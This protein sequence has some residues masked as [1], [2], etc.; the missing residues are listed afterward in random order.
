[1]EEY[2]QRLE[3]EIDGIL[4]KK[5]ENAQEYEKNQ[6][7]RYK[8]LVWYAVSIYLYNQLYRYF[9]PLLSDKDMYSLYNGITN[10]LNYMRSENESPFSME[11]PHNGDETYKS[12]I[13]DTHVA[14]I[15]EKIP[16]CLLSLLKDF[17][18]IEVFYRVRV[19][20]DLIQ[21]VLEDSTKN[22]ESSKKEK[23]DPTKNKE[24]SK[25]KEDSREIL[26]IGFL[27]KDNYFQLLFCEE[28]E[29][30]KD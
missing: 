10:F 12:A 17:R 30:G 8:A 26:E 3:K 18:G 21:E 24:S 20:H 23:E 1:M 25:K 5:K 13:K 14:K 29:E 19:K 4:E 6:I 28:K 16:E 7:K 15:I 27:K 22:K 9:L 2:R 11:Y